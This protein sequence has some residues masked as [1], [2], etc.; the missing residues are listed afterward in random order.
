MFV[1]VSQYH[2]SLPSVSLY[3]PASLHQV[4]IP[5]S[6]RRSAGYLRSTASF[7]D[8]RW[9]LDTVVLEFKGKPQTLTIVNNSKQLW[10]CYFMSKLDKL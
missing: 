10:V 4:L 8:G 3:V 9:E 2:V 7:R 6:G 1:H 5:V